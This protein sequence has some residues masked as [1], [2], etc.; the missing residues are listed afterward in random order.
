MRLLDLYLI[1]NCVRE[2]CIDHLWRVVPLLGC[3]VPKR[4]AEAVRHS[5]D[6]NVLEHLG[7]RRRG[8]RLPDPHGEQKRFITSEL[9]RPVENLHRSRP[10]RASAPARAGWPRRARQSRRRCGQVRG[11]RPRMTS[12][13]F[14]LQLLVGW[15]KTYMPLPPAC[16]PGGA[17]RT[18]ATESALS[19]WGPR[20]LVLRGAATAVIIA[21]IAAS[22][23]RIGWILPF[24]PTGP[25]ARL[26]FINLY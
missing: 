11:G 12:R 22:N 15:T 21:S 6:P 17:V 2:R 18:K 1:L 20:R 24:V 3:R 16:R 23:S 14:Q 5:R 26:H 4:R 8:N 19:G 10:A 9:T 25:G 13:W 7:R